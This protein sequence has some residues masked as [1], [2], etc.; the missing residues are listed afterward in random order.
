[1]DLEQRWHT[2]NFALKTLFCV[3]RPSMWCF[4]LFFVRYFKF[5]KYGLAMY[6]VKAARGMTESDA[7]LIFLKLSAVPILWWLP[8]A[9]VA[10]YFIIQF[11][12]RRLY[13]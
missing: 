10:D 9:L 5:E 2:R 6:G 3:M 12:A 4:A 13:R 8:V 11:L 1:M 7:M